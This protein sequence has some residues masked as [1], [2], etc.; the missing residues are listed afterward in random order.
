MHYMSFQLL[1]S[2]FLESSV[3]PNEDK[4]NRNDLM[5]TLQQNCSAKRVEDYQ[6]VL[7]DEDLEC[8]LNLIYR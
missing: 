6:M 5:L 4:I 2:K 7:C 1:C 8:H 3:E